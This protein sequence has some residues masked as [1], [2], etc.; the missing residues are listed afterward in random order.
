VLF[1]SFI[2]SLISVKS[3]RLYFIYW[4]KR[5]IEVNWICL[6]VYSSL[7]FS[8]I[9]LYIFWSSI[10]GGT[11][12]I[13]VLDYVLINWFPYQYEMTSVSTGSPLCSEVNF[14]IN[15]AVQT[16]FWLVSVWHIFFHSFTFNLVKIYKV[17]FNPYPYERQ[18]HQLKY[19]DYIPFPLSTSS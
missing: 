12:C 3:L 19:Q 14:D 4:L 1:K 13:N 6:S 5:G 15:L 17:H 2:A 7:Q 10:V 18:I 16:F 9:L 11:R 8:D